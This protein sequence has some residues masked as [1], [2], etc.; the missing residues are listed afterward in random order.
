MARITHEEIE[1]LSIAERVALVE[2]IWD[3]I[4]AAPD[5]LPLTEA[6]RRE[7]D[8]RLALHEREPDRA[9]PWEEVRAKLQRGS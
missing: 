9:I 5:L 6:Q 7:L 8:R 3:S 2:E 4:A 1:R